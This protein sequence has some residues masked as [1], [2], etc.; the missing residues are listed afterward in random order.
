MRN[1]LD[2]IDVKPD[3][4][5]DFLI[6]FKKQKKIKKTKTKQKQKKTKK[7]GNY[8]PYIFKGLDYLFILF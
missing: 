7:K 6:K 1:V 8:T 5:S 3:R 2:S 4:G